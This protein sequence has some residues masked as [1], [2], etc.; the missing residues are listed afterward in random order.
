MSNFQTPC[1]RR[2]LPQEIIDVIICRYNLG[3]QRHAWADFNCVYKAHR[4]IKAAS[5]QND[6][7]CPD[8]VPPLP[9]VLDYPDLDLERNCLRV[10][11]CFAEYWEEFT[12]DLWLNYTFDEWV[13]FQTNAN[14]VLDWND[15]TP[16]QWQN[17]TL[18]EW[19][20]LNF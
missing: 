9:N 16:D 10:A 4:A 3:S 8:D 13:R 20:N 12:S 14:I 15:F 6:I 18:S 1:S 2:R 11:D 5:E 17:M 19:A 7:F